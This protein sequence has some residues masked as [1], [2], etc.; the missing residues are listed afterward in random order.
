[1]L[2]INAHACDA[3]DGSS[4]CV[5]CHRVEIFRSTGI[6]DIMDSDAAAKSTTV[7]NHCRK[8]QKSLC[9]NAMPYVV[10]RAY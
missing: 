4:Q 5:M 10:K 7:K 2:T 1:M 9:A 6:T 8:R 3:S